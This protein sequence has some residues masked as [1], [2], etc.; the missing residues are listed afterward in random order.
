MSESNDPQRCE[1]LELNVT[2]IQGQMSELVS[3]MRQLT[4]TRT[5][6]FGQREEKSGGT[7][8]GAAH[9]YSGG[10]G[11]VPPT[12]D[13]GYGATVLGTTTVAEVPVHSRVAS[14]PGRPAD[15]TGR[16]PVL[17]AGVGP[18]IDVQHGKARVPYFAVIAAHDEGGGVMTDFKSLSARAIPPV[19]EAEKRGFQKFKHEFLLETNMLDISVH[20]VGQGMQMVPVGDPLKAKA[21]LLRE[22]FSNEEIRGACQAWNFIDAALKSEARR[23]ILKRCRSP[24]EVFE[25]LE[26]WHDPESETATQRLYD[27]VHEFAIPPHSNPIAALHHLEN[28]NNQMHENRI[29]RIPEIVLHARFVRARPDEY[30]LVKETL[31]SMKNRDRDEI[32]R[33]IST[34]YS[35]LP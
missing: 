19:L 12:A 26:K 16:R 25:S 20:F 18:M 32:I 7:R 21:A 29:G 24:R 9:N 13:T 3:M 1:A 35:D 14:E 5:A 4:Q 30:S 27:K 15:D 23:A 10:A 17:S 34:R 31:Q 8:R 28:I 22:G 2:E 33:M 6:G 11:R